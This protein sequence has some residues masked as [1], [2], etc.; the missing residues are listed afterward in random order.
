MKI[1]D[2]VRFPKIEGVHYEATIIGINADT[3]PSLLTVEVHYD[4]CVVVTTTTEDDAELIPGHPLVAPY[5][6]D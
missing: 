3:V 1:G 5:E 6:Q 4:T 2:K